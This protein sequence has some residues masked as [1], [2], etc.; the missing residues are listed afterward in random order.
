LQQILCPPAIDP[1]LSPVKNWTGFLASPS[2]SAQKRLAPLSPSALLKTPSPARLLQRPIMFTNIGNLLTP[3]S[4]NLKKLIENILK[5][6][7]EKATKSSFEEEEENEEEKMELN[8][9]QREE[10][11]EMEIEEEKKPKKTKKKMAKPKKEKPNYISLNLR[12]RQFAPISKFRGKGKRRW[13]GKS[14][15]IDW[16]RRRG[17]FRR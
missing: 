13:S 14:G 1:F 2:R 5:F 11:D 3:G 15:G 8:E 6:F 12:R 10:M 17:L 16:N 4:S 9:N 7:L